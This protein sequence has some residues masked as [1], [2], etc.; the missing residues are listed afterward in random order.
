[1]WSGDFI[2]VYSDPTSRCTED[3]PKVLLAQITGLQPNLPILRG[4]GCIFV[5]FVTDAN[6]EQSYGD[7]DNTGDG[8]VARVGKSSSCGSCN[9]F[10]CSENGLCECNGIRWG[11]DCSF[12]DHCLGTS[13]IV[14]SETNEP[15]KI[16]SSYSV[17]NGLASSAL[18]LYPNDL[19]CHFEVKVA[20]SEKY[21]IFEVEY[22]LETTFDMLELYS[23]SLGSEPGVTLYTV[24][25]G[26]SD[27][28]REKYYIPTD[29]DGIV[30]IRLVTDSRGR[31]AGFSGSVWTESRDDPPTSCDIGESGLFCEVPHCI[32]QNSLGRDMGS[33]SHLKHSYQIGRVVS[34]S[35]EASA[36]PVSSTCSW[37]LSEVPPPAATAGIR[38]VFNSPLDLEPHL[39][40]AV[41]DKLVIQSDAGTVEVFAEKC[42][43]DDQCVYDWQVIPN[44]VKLSSLILVSIFSTHKFHISPTIYPNR[45]VSVMKPVAHAL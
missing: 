2:R 42:S 28:G 30:T 38:L 43:S 11:S 37:S 22:D 18:E 40:S 3:S 4:A 44:K 5:E 10:P 36:L 1:V 13:H 32:A 27:R 21:V 23:G 6:Q 9:G 33:S 35:S 8:F 12:T 26:V 16:A 34:N 19:D 24:L 15:E 31:R 20:N 39:S 45:L 14:L 25:T 41:G 29:S 7:S 17:R